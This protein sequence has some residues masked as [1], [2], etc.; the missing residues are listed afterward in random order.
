M[1][2][3]LARA[4]HLDGSIQDWLGAPTAA[5]W[6]LVL[7]DIWRSMGFY[8]VLLYAGLVDVPEDMLESARLDGASGLPARPQHRA[9]RC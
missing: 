9:A 1:N 7:M 4:R 6:I 8:A 2:S 3:A 5:F